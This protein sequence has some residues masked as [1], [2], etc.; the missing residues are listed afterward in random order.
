M[1]GFYLKDKLC[2]VFLDGSFLSLKILPPYKLLLILGEK[3]R[4][5]FIFFS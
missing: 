5:N 1:E 2:T 4:A 3:S